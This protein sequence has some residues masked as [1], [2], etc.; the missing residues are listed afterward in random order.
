M[1]EDTDLGM[2]KVGEGDETTD[3][4]ELVSC[5]CT[6]PECVGTDIHGIGTVAY[7]LD[8]GVGVSCGSEKL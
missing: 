7:G 1:Q 8:A 3:V 2:E 4:V 5:G 6:R